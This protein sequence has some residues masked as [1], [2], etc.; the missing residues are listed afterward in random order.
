MRP[1]LPILLLGC[2][3]E[4]REAERRQQALA[5]EIALL[6][7]EVGALRNAMRAAGIRAESA[8]VRKGRNRGRGGARGRQPDLA[9]AE[10]HADELGF[11]ITRSG[12]L[13]SL[14]AGAVQAIDGCGQKLEVPQLK[15]ISDFQL[16]QRGRGKSSPVRLE[17]AGVEL[18]PH[19]FPKDFETCTGSFRHAGTVVLFSP[20]SADADLGSL[21]LHFDERFPSADA[22]GTPRYWLHPGQH[23]EIS[24][25]D[26]W[27]EEWGAPRLLL[28]V[29]GPAPEITVDGE[30][31][32]PS[33]PLEGDGPWLIDLAATDHVLINA[34]GI[35]NPQHLVMIVSP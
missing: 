15:R 13:P 21:R 16:T 28:D 22:E 33:R 11:S 19:G 27:S 7:Q 9:S 31:F 2:N 20:A 32:D 8:P 10:D 3:P 26:A 24:S 23:A 6:E 29:D 34:L 30:P 1:L 12:P 25:E 35:G 4:I 18:R 14:D 17:V 5:S